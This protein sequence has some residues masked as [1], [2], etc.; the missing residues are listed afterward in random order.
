MSAKQT[1]YVR[2]IKLKFCK[3]LPIMA[4]K[5]YTVTKNKSTAILLGL[6]ISTIENGRERKSASD[7]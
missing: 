6:K 1:V 7:N 4:T 3:F 2:H 5:R